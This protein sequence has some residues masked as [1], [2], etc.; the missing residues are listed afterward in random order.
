MTW[1]STINYVKDMETQSIKD[2][3][4]YELRLVQSTPIEGDVGCE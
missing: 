1:K 2:E 4:E 3:M